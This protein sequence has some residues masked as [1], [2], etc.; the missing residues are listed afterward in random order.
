[1]YQNLPSLIAARS[2]YPEVIAPVYLVYGE[3]D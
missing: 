2:R 1:M 3:K